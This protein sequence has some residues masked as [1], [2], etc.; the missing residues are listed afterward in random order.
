MT[1]E[2][3][4]AGNLT[5][6][7][8][9]AHPS[10]L[11]PNFRRTIVFLSHHSADDGAVGFILN[12]P[13]GKSL[14]QASSASVVSSTLRTVPILDGGPVG[15][16]ELLLASI[17]WRT[18]PEAVAFRGFG[19]VASAEEVPPEFLNGLRA[20][21]GYAGWSRGQLESEIAE[22]A[23]LIAPP[24][25]ALIEISDPE[26]IWG[27]YLSTLDPIFRLYAEAPDDPTLN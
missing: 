2:P 7:L 12:R 27:D 22:R 13:T 21:R 20:F 18:N 19:A 8:L 17:Q 3:P 26:R 23:W 14:G 24:I 9:V 4:H 15:A 1:R 16:D 10:L 25:R 11:D 6:S 5:G